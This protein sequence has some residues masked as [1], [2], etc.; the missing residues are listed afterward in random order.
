MLDCR[1]YRPD[2]GDSGLRCE[3]D[4]TPP[5][6]S[7]EDGPLGLSQEAWL[8]T[9]LRTQRLTLSWSHAVAASRL[10][11][12]DSWAS[13][14]VAENRLLDFIDSAGIEGVAF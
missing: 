10:R 7:R 14:D 11:G 8:R 12:T 2:I 1:M 4:P 13:Y 3:V 6:L 9:Q 5:Q